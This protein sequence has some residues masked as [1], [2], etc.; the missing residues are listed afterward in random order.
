[1]VLEHNVTLANDTVVMCVLAV[2]CLGGRRSCMGLQ[3]LDLLGQC[4][5]C[6]GEELP[7]RPWAVGLLLPRTSTSRPRADRLVRARLTPILPCLRTAVTARGSVRSPTATR[8]ATPS[9]PGSSPT[10][11]TRPRT[12]PRT[13]PRSSSAASTSSGQSSPAP[14]TSTTSSGRAPRRPRSSS[15]PGPGA[16]SARRCRAC[17]TCR[18]ASARAV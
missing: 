11:S 12:S 6:G 7:N 2:V 8:G 18:T 3:G 9:R 4:G 17:T 14:R 16:T 5:C 1:M 10:A 13:R 15:G